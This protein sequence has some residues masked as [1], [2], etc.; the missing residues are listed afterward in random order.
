MLYAYVLTTS[1]FEKSGLANKKGAAKAISASFVTT[2]GAGLPSAYGSNVN[3][4]CASLRNLPIAAEGF[5]KSA[6]SCCVYVTCPARYQSHNSQG[7]LP[8]DADPSSPAPTVNL[9]LP[10]PSCPAL[11][12]KKKYIFDKKM[13]F[14]YPI[15]D[16]PSHGKM[17]EDVKP[18][19]EDGVDGRGFPGGI[20]GCVVWV[21]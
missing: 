8:L 5:D 18:E 19:D 10:L 17:E 9:C 14:F 13:N 21:R 12:P 20:R 11:T 2:V 3:A 7:S 6:T 1:V 15:L 16:P 4:Y